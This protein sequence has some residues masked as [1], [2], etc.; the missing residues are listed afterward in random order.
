MFSPFILLMEK[1]GLQEGRT[2]KFIAEL[3]HS[4]SRSLLPH[5]SAVSSSKL[6][7]SCN[8]H[9]G[10]PV[11]FWIQFEACNAL[12]DKWPIVSFWKILLILLVPLTSHLNGYCI[13]A[14]IYFSFDVS[15]MYFYWL[16]QPRVF[17]LG[18]TDEIQGVLEFRPGK[19]CI[20]VFT[21]T[22]M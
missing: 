14:G 22:Q 19:H 11:P 10:S 21:I 20:S 7:F 15:Q 16:F 8:L 5:F 3:D 17:N 18:S 2:F 13:F 1:L 6:L 9:E 12:A 4:T